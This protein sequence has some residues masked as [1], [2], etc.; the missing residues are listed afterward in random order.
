MK[1]EVRRITSRTQGAS[2]EPIIAEL[3]GVLK[4]WFTNFK[5]AR[6]ETFRALLTASFAPNTYFAVR[7]LFTLSEAHE[8]G[9]QSR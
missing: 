3:N 2:M 7:G 1:D 5:H 9:G 6:T 8:K 4:G